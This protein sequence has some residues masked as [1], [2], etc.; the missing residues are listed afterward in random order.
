[1][2]NIFE[3]SQIISSTVNV[4]QFMRRHSL[5]KSELNCCGNNCSKVMDISIKDQEIFQCNTCHKH[6]SIRT[7]SFYFHSNLTLQVHIFILFF[8]SNG[9]KVTELLRFL[10]G[11]CSQKIAIQWYSYYRDVMT[12]HLAHNPP[13]FNSLVHVDE[14][15][16][17]GK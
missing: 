5:L 16:V 4:I 12:T 17:G 14:T 1:M 13:M 8:F 9:S 6:Y 3:L 2:A 11:K 7:N 10:D 15:A